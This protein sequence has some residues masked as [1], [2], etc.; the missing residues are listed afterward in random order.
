MRQRG[1]CRSRLNLTQTGFAL[2]TSCLIELRDDVFGNSRVADQHVLETRPLADAV[3]SGPVM[4]RKGLAHCGDAPPHLT[5]RSVPSLLLNGRDTAAGEI[6]HDGD[7]RATLENCRARATGDLKLCNF[8]TCASGY[9][10][11]LT[12]EPQHCAWR[13]K[14]RPQAETLPAAPRTVSPGREDCRRGE[15]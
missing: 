15:T 5:Y 12:S 10:S 14:S 11:S 9:K 6:P 8:K 4:L 13:F 3:S 7:R 1:V 2:W